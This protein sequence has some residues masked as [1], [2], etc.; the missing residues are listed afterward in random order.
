M[1]LTVQAPGSAI[2]GYAA[3]NVEENKKGVSEK[4][5]VFA[6]NLKAG[7]AGSAIDEK[8]QNA[9]NQ[10]MKLIHDAWKNDDKAVQSRE[11]MKKRKDEKLSELHEYDARLKEIEDK[12]RRFRKSMVL[13]RILR[14]REIWNFWKN[15][16]TM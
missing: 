10:A 8:R 12:K 1:S 7:A 14:S 4:G 6:G 5:T 3:G 2:N 9:R 15:T 11:D 16:R 13:T